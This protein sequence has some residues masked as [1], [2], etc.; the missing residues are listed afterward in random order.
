MSGEIYLVS[1]ITFATMALWLHLRIRTVN[2]LTRR[3]PTHLSSC[4]ERREDDLDE[5]TVAFLD[6]E[7]DE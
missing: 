6:E 7:E 3:N 5:V 4:M 1:A 2:S